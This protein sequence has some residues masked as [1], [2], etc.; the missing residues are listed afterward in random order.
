VPLDCPETQANHQF[1]HASQSLLLHANLAHKDHPA[2][3]DQLDHL[4][5]PELPDNPETQEPTL[6]PANPVQKDLPAHPESPVLLVPLASLVPLLKANLWSPENQDQLEKPDHPDLPVNLDNPAPMEP[7]DPLDPKDPLAPTDH[8]D[9]TVNPDPLANP[10][11]LEAPARR[12]SARNT[13]PSTV[14]SSSKMEPGA[15]LDKILVASL[16]RF[17]QVSSAASLASAVVSSLF[18]LSSSFRHFPP[19]VSLS[20]L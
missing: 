16:P 4:A 19:F 6:H 13:V 9:K 5:M 3:P 10:A 7:Q 18:S 15:K 14:V 17:I 20:K 1:N 12:V 8:P 2:H 11:Q